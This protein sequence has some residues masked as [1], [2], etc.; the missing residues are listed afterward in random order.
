MRFPIKAVRVAMIVLMF[1]AVAIAFLTRS[2]RV[3]ALFYGDT[4]YIPAVF[5]DIFLNDGSFSDWYFA[6][7]PYFFPDMALYFLIKAIIGSTYFS[8]L[9]YALLQIGATYILIVLL[10]NILSTVDQS[11]TKNHILKNR[12]DISLLA[13]LYAI[14]FLA[15]QGQDSEIGIANSPYFWIISSVFHFGNIMNGLFAI[16]MTL[17][18]LEG[19]NI[20]KA[21]I[22][23]FLIS[24]LGTGSD[25]LFIVSFMAP[26]IAAII[27]STVIYKLKKMTTL[28]I[29]V[30]SF[31][32]ATTG[33]LLKL[34]L[35]VNTTAT[36]ILR[37]HDLIGQTKALASVLLISFRYMPIA[38]ILATVFYG[39]LIW[40]VIRH[41][42]GK[43]Q[44]A[45]H[46]Y[47]YVFILASVSF[48]FAALIING[49]LGFN[50]HGTTRYFLNF[51]WLPVL[52]SWL[53]VD[54]FSV[55]Q[56]RLYR[57]A[58]NTVFL[59][60][61]L[62][63]GYLSVPRDEFQSTYYPAIAQC[64][65]NAL[66]SYEAKTGVEISQGIAAYGP[67]KIVT[68]FSKRN[69]EVVQVRPNLSPFLWVNNITRYRPSYDFAI[70]EQL[71]HGEVPNTQILTRINGAPEYEVACQT[72]PRAKVL[73]YGKDNLRS[74]KLLNIG[75]SYT[76]KGCELSIRSGAI[77]Q[78]DCS[79]QTQSESFE[80]TLTFGP[81]EPLPKGEYQF[82]IRY[83][84][85]PM[86]TEKVG[87]W[88]IIIHLPEGIEQLQKGD[89]NGTNGQDSQVSVSSLSIS[90]NYANKDIEV[91]T[92]ANG[93]GT[94]KVSGIT[95]TKIK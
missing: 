53:V 13:F 91:K 20:V 51:Y 60:A 76:W 23:L 28:R 9:F 21:Y 83:S 69:A 34:A 27:L 48:T 24:L 18:I 81:Y 77:A 94:L 57:Y 32:G 85:P 46:F 31:L 63:T 22:L 7:A 78:E 3:S 6:P 95:F 5:R 36:Y 58:R 10:I 90:G 84:S 44:G 45:N 37:E 66:A 88:E 40:E 59:I 62:G 73:I 72:R 82:E 2:L 87:E 12:F 29:I 68:E 33:I 55:T 65:D 61:L 49:V 47:L 92:I 93:S 26:S 86:P 14:V 75:D 25:A 30:V 43:K 74:E 89:L 42:R 67:S 70:I 16:A 54:I 64:V 4:L 80:G 71:P 11:S 41:L 56:N 35:T 39:I 8:A 19:K 15:I 38:L 17:A 1:S 79:V 50:D 52:F